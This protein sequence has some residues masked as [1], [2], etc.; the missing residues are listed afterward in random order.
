MTAELSPRIPLT[1]NVTDVALVFEGGGMRASYTA[2]VAQVLLEQGIHFDWVSGI[3]AGSS[4]AVNYLSRDIARTASSFVDSPADPNFGGLRTMLQGKG[5]FAAEYI[6]E[7]TAGPDEV[8][9]FDFETFR[10]NPAQLRVG[11]FRCRDGEPVWFT[12]DDMRTLPDLM[13]RVRASSSMPF[14]MPLTFIDGEAYLDGA[15]GPSG[16]IPVQPALD[17]GFERVFVVLTRP[18]SRLMRPY[19]L[20]PLLRAAW[21]TYP[22]VAEALIGRWRRYNATREMLFDLEASG[23]ALIF[24]PTHVFVTTATRSVPTL[25][26]SYAA[27]LAQARRELPLWRDFLGM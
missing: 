25:R 11:A 6:Y 13:R 7:H 23:R 21:H 24:A 5:L 12:Q 8:L 26:M 17:E 20:S 4:N 27:G 18:R 9:P 16:G 15:L 1:N 10:A 19:H 3:S 2:P 14:A 22:A